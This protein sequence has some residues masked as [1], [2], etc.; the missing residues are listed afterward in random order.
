MQLMIPS[1]RVL[2]TIYKT[3]W[4]NV[5]EGSVRSSKTLTSTMA[6]L[7]YIS[8]SDDQYFLMTGKTQGSL[9]RNVIEG[10]AGLMAMVPTAKLRYTKASAIL[11]IPTPKGVKT[12]YCF[13]AGDADSYKPIRGVT[14]GG[15][16]ADEISEHHPTAIQ[17]CFNRTVVS[18]D[19]RHF[20]TL[21]PQNPMH[22]IYTEYLDKYDAM[23]PEENKAAGG[24]YWHHFT[25][26]DNPAITQETRDALKLQYIGYAYKRYVLGLRVIAE[27]LIYPMVNDSHFIDFDRSRVNCRYA[28]IDFGTNHATV[29][30]IG[31]MYDND[32]NDWRICYEYYD[33]GS[34]K[35]SAD[36]AEDFIQLCLKNDIDPY[37][38]QIA[39]DPAAGVLKNSFRK[40]GLNV[41]NAKN[42]VLNGIML[43]SMY[44]NQHRLR[45]HKSCKMHRVEFNIYAWDEKATERGEDK[46]IK[47]ND[48]C[49]DTD[50]Y[51][52]NTFMRPLI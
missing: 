2:R 46:P 13:G 11:E 17:E 50:R 26:E 30:D 22:A 35:D 39:I 3:G 33:K 18:K 29:F 41:I 15:W 34:G 32:K 51:F 48:D 25:L 16:Y 37:H 4:L 52:G 42:D 47:L 31:G 36:Y 21:N 5:W 1:K 24:Y 44:Y 8:K 6:W 19:R 27:G 23:T 40:R 38:I 14:V 49:M 28:A 7:Y 43:L 12:C 9:I 45:F 20:W 10:D